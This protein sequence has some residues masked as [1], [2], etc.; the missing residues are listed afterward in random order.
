MSNTL[1]FV[2]L[3]LG[4]TT[5]V[6]ILSKIRKLKVKMEDAIFWVI[7]AGI[8]CLL[9][10]FPE[11]TYILTELLGVMSPANLV[12][13]VIIFILLEKVFTLSIVVSQLEEKV[14]I[15]AA[16]MALRSHSAEK[17]LDEDSEILATI[18]RKDSETESRNTIDGKGINH[19]SNI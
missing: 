7:L 17:R 14:T 15:L 11:V 1:R 18:E 16:E 19:C 5:A 2:L 10:L 8:L 3:V 9:S 6:W 13:L 12:F 4:L